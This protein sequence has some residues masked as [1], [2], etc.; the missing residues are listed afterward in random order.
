MPV[1]GDGQLRAIQEL[2]SIEKGSGE[3][4]TVEQCFEKI[5]PLKV[6]S[7]QVRLAQVG[8]SEIGTPKIRSGKIVPA[9]IEPAQ[10]SL[11]EV[12]SL[13]SFRPP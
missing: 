10:T 7:R 8:S 2:G 13:V 9:Q 1:P 6:G 12:W 11:R 4:R 3:V 5:C